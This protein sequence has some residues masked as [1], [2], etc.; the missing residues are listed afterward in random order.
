M[1]RKPDYTL[2]HFHGRVVRHYDAFNHLTSLG[3]DLLWRRATARRVARHLKREALVLDVGCG[4]GD[5]ALA[6][7][8]AASGVTPVGLDPSVEM[9]ERLSMKRRGA[10]LPLVCAVN[11]YPFQPA[12]FD[13]ITGAFVFRNFTRLPAD[14]EE[15]HRLLRSGGRLYALDFY[16]PE[17]LI[18]HL[19]LRALESSIVPII[20]W[21]LTGNSAPYRYLCASIRRF[22]SAAEF[23]NILRETG[24]ADVHRHSFFF[25]LVNLIVAQKS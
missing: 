2:Y 22:R 10:A 4:T 23:E 19:M 12:R 3:L 18:P 24:Y 15:L 1:K 21:L 16:R 14:L 20:G 7:L 8:R 5:M 17:R 6:V 25:G 13:A 9:L 11:P